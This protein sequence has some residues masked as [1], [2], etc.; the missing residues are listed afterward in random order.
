MKR[1]KFFLWKFS[2]F[3]PY[4]FQF[5]AMAWFQK[6]REKIFNAGSI[7]FIIVFSKSFCGRF[8]SKG[9]RRKGNFLKGLTLKH[10]IKRDLMFSIPNMH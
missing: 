5:S 3:H 6:D 4:I 1:G 8:M 10:E 7:F 2:S 9:V